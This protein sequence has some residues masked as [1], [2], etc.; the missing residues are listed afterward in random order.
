MYVIKEDGNTCL[1]LN[2]KKHDN[3]GVALA[4][5]M[6]VHPLSH[7]QIVPF[8]SRD[9]RALGKHFHELPLFKAQLKALR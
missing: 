9:V 6:Y 3:K 5:C 8:T 4:L 1:F 7:G 2:T